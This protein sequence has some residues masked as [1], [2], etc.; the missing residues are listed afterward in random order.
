MQK[1]NYYEHQENVELA[2]SVCEEIGINREIALKGI[3]KNKPD[4]GA[5]VIWKIK[6][7]NSVNQFVSAFAANDPQ[8]TLDIC[9]KLSKIFRLLYF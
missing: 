5:L 7:N 1:F 2:L 3:L 9:N 4:P 8:S 6:I